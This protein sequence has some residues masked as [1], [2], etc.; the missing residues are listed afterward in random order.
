MFGRDA[1][2]TGSR[3][4]CRVR[5]G[6]DQLAIAEVHDNSDLKAIAIRG[7]RPGA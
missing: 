3:I 1:I 6:G 5:H 7:E 4:P 2:D